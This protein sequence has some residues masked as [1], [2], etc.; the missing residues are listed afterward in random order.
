MALRILY[1][2]RVSGSASLRETFM[3][4]GH[5]PCPT[6]PPR[7]LGASAAS[8]QNQALPALLFLYRQVLG[9]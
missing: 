5:T 7:L 6:T 8:T 2:Y 3:R 4:E 9:V 1:E